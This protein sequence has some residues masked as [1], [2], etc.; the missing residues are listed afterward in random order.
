MH[1]TKSSPFLYSQALCG[2]P[3]CSQQSIQ[4]N[5]HALST[6]CTQQDLNTKKSPGGFLVS[7]MSSYPAIRTA[8]CLTNNT[9]FEKADSSINGH[10]LCFAQ[11]LD[12]VERT[13]GV[14]FDLPTM[15]LLFKGDQ[16]LLAKVL[17]KPESDQDRHVQLAAFCNDCL[18]AE[19]SLVR[20]V[21]N[22]KVKND[23]VKTA[24]D[25][26]GE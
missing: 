25:L 19:Y 24:N 12:G 10:P 20:D 3:A 6:S 17:R 21:K 14:T 16:G 15:N 18:K 23:F 9:A 8:G 13:K 1:R 5:L 2:R 26:C 7:G 22:S 4:T 11:L